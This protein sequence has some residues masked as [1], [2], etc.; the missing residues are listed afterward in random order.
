MPKTARA[1]L[2]G[3]PILLILTWALCLAV[4]LVELP[5]WLNPALEAGGE[6]IMGTHDAYAWLAGAKGVGTFVGK[7]L[8][9]LVA[10]VHALTSASFGAIGF[11]LPPLMASLAGLPLVVLARRWGVASWGPAAGLV[12]GSALGFLIRT[13]IAMLDT[14]I[15]SLLGPT[16]AAVWLCVLLE[17]VLRPRWLFG[18]REPGGDSQPQAA[19]ESR[20]F[21]L[22]LAGLCLW[23]AFSRWFYPGINSIYV[24]LFGLAALPGVH[25][26]LPGRRAL[27]LSA[28]VLPLAALDGPHWLAQGVAPAV[29]ILLWAAPRLRTRSTVLWGAAAGALLLFAVH[30]W[31]LI[32]SALMYV[33][34]YFRP[35]SEVV[36]SAQV[37]TTSLNLPS[38]VAS[39][40]ETQNL[41][42]L[43]IL[44]FAAGHPALFFVFLAGYVWLVLRRP[45]AVI[46]LPLL[47]LGLASIKLGARFSMFAVP[48]M[49]AGV[50]GL[51]LLC[52]QRLTRP[53]LAQGAA[54][55][56]ALA[57][58]VPLVLYMRQLPPL[59]VL[60]RP[61]AETLI[62]LGRDTAPSAWVWQWWDFGYAT[63]Y[64]ADRFPVADGARHTKEWLYPVAAVHAA[65]PKRAADLMRFFASEMAEQKLSETLR[66]TWTINPAYLHQFTPPMKRLLVMDGNEALGLL[67]GIDEGTA[68][69]P[70]AAEAP[71]QIYVAAW[72]NLKLAG[73]II[74]LGTWNL[75]DGKFR[76]GNVTRLQGDLRLDPNRGVAMT[77]MLGNLPL[78]TLDVASEAGT[79]HTAWPRVSGVHLVMNT[80]A[81]EAYIMDQAAYRSSMIQMLVREPRDFA[82]DFDLVRDNAPWSR[83]YRLRPQR[84]GDG[85]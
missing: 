22:S 37:A 38:V 8:A 62:G 65:E 43:E 57:V 14:D 10:L 55:L 52:A 3:L 84:E 2:T 26:A 66:E 68:T 40:R 30:G 76:E 28:A 44:S 18:S 17:P 5:N 58:L 24:A 34:Y 72:D 41:P 11:W 59:P 20:S 77:A 29:C 15:L 71:D 6:P 81:R 60:S 1:F 35:S 12:G 27:A 47:L 36:T 80:M 82:D 21:W 48:V 33:Q 78:S 45:V 42:I 63:Q 64:Y 9:R 19:E 79:K 16:L 23:V 85:N 56:A 46:F 31:S 51:G 25:L 13:R 83:V 39:I 49:G 69:R 74:R 67:K 7:S 61:Y 4:R 53:A 75:A 50:I 32:H 73:W 70:L 54:A